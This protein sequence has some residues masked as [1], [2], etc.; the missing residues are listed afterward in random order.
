MRVFLVNYAQPEP[1]CPDYEVAAT[2]VR[3]ACEMAAEA[4]RAHPMDLFAVPK[5]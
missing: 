2:S 3:E 5:P 4:F 1:G